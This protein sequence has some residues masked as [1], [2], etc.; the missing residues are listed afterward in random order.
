MI[1]RATA[2][3]I[4]LLALGTH[5]AATEWRMDPDQSRLEFVARWEGNEVPGVFRE[6]DTRL[7]L[8]PDAP[9]NSRLEVVVAIVSAD[10]DSDDINEGIA[11]SE[12]FDSARF[13]QAR[14][15][16]T[17]IQA[18]GDQR[19]EALGTLTLKDAAREV[20]VPFAFTETGT[21]ARM[22]GELSLQRTD[23]NIGTGEWSAGDII[24]LEVDVRFEVALEPE[25]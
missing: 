17:A 10:M 4:T 7:S 3:L 24:G 25:G 19:Y 2:W 5:A 16:S 9:E 21:G 13:P 14:F 12:W 20:R 6:F 11:G 22:S 15:T 8:R 23:F 18:L 1:G